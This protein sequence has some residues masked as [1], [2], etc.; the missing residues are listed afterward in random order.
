MFEPSTDGCKEALPIYELVRA[1]RVHH[2]VAEVDARAQLPAAQPRLRLA[3]GRGALRV[4]IV[5]GGCQA[6][7]PPGLAHGLLL[8]APT[9]AI[10]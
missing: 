4:C 5:L 1:Q 10:E 9:V 7:F 2:G 6:P 3:I 8:T